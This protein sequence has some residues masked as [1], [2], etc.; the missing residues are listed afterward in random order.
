MDAKNVSKNEAFF[1]IDF[2]RFLAPTCLPNPE[3]KWKSSKSADG[4]QD[5]RGKFHTKIDTSQVIFGEFQKFQKK[6]LL[7]LCG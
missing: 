3:I 2:D 4:N 7:F 6:S 5:S 1:D